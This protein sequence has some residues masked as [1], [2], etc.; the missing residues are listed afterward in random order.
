M[1]P[2]NAPLP[3]IPAIPARRATAA[4]AAVG[5]LISA[6]LTWV[7]YSGSLALCVGVGGCEAVQTSRY[8]MVGTVPVALI[9]L[10]GFV[11]I[12][13]VA[14]ARVRWPRPELDLALFAL[15]L[16]ATLYVL[17]LSY[18]EVVVLGA[19]CPWCVAVAVCAGAVFV[20]AARAVL[21]PP[22]A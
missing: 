13:A 20:A 22:S 4:I 7:H 17:Y 10:G 18:V 15:S 5:T 3:A 6:Y 1:G 16:T 11:T 12:L 8:A 14:L 2:S 21:N 19:I 9:G